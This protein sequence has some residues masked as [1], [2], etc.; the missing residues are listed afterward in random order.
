MFAPVFEAMKELQG[1]DD[2][3]IKTVEAKL[4]FEVERL[5]RQYEKDYQLNADRQSDEYCALRDR[6]TVLEQLLGHR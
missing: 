6:V 3:I 5:A 1:R 2:S 4:K